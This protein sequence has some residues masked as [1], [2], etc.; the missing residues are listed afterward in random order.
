MEHLLR[1]TTKMQKHHIHLSVKPPLIIIYLLEW[2]DL[3]DCLWWR[4]EEAE[5]VDLLLLD[6]LGFSMAAICSKTSATSFI[7]GRFLG[8]C[9]K[10]LRVSWAACAAA[11]DEY[12]PCSRASMMVFSFRFWER[13]GFIQSTRFCCARCVSRALEPVSSSSSTTPYPYTSL[14]TYRCPIVKKNSK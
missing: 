8:S 7:G 9:S 2:C 10:H 13:R 12:W 1:V 3:G 5:C 11:L 4:D 6:T 14:F